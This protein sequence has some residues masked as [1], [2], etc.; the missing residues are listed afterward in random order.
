MSLDDLDGLIGRAILL[1]SVWATWEQRSL[2]VSGARRVGKTELLKVAC[3]HAPDPFV[4]VHVDLLSCS[5]I[6]EA[7]GGLERALD[8]VG[9]GAGV[10]SAVSERIDSVVA[11]GVQIST[12]TRAP[13][14]GWERFEEVVDRGIERLD[15]GRILVVALDEVAWWLDDLEAEGQGEARRGLM[16]LSRLRSAWPVRLRLVL[17]GSVRI[18]AVAEQYGATEALRDWE[19]LEVPPLEPWATEALLEIGL[20]LDRSCNKVAPGALALIQRATGGSPHWTKRVVPV[21]EY[22][23][24]VAEDDARRALEVILRSDSDEFRSYGIAHFR[25]RRDEAVCRRLFAILEAA[26]RTGSLPRE[27]A[28]TVALAA[29]PGTTRFE[30]QR[31]LELLEDEY[32]LARDEGGGF[33]FVT[34]LLGSWWALAGGRA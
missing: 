6:D 3:R 12:R 34:P 5:T 14:S 31:A 21:I 19:E 16:R 24:T 23:G 29:S 10:L 20:L 17:T 4:A 1:R 32:F 28:I 18:R 13:R 27:A 25:R 9:L 33:G 8:G 22:E 7:A 26:A 30:A 15:D 2:L 11:G